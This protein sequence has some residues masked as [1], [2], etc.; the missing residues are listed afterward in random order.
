MKRILIV[1]FDYYPHE[2]GKSTHMKYLIK[3]L[4]ELGAQ[5]DI[6]SRDS[7]GK[8]RMFFIKIFAQIYKLFGIASYLFHKKQMEKRLFKKLLNKKAKNSYEMISFQDAISCSLLADEIA[9]NCKVSLTMHTYFGLENSLDNNALT[10]GNQYYK[11]MLRDELSSLKK[12]KSIIAVDKSIEN[13]IK[14]TL[15]SER[16]TDVAVFCIKNFID[17]SSFPDLHSHI[18]DGDIDAICVRRL[19]EKNGV[20]FAVKAFEILGKGFRLHIVGDGPEYATIKK[21]ICD[22]GLD[23]NVILY[24]AIDNEHIVPIYEKCNCAIVPSITVNGLQEATSISA[25]EAMSCGLPIVVSGIGG[26]AELVTNE[27]NGYIAKEK[28]YEHIASIFRRINENRVKASAIGE[29]A[30]DYVHRNHSH[31][32][33]ATL[34]LNIFDS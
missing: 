3:G 34:Y 2:G 21:Y 31:I 15:E 17:T 16:V 27:I 5:C 19:V 32:N 23:E 11:K 12:I 14:K 6:L 4:N 25:L 10:L 20:L 18:L 9:T 29:K 13:H 33:A 28:D 7:L 30:R 24:G 22:R 26:L 1:T 8:T